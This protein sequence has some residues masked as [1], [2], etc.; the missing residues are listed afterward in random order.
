MPH[1]P[2][3]CARREF[4]HA[5]WTF[6][7]EHGCVTWRRRFLDF[8][9]V[10]AICI[11]EEA[12]RRPVPPGGGIVTLPS[13]SGRGT[14]GSQGEGPQRGRPTCAN[15]PGASALPPLTMPLRGALLPRGERHV[16]AP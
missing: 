4:R 2:H 13:P 15:T 8:L 3:P 11:E 5:S 1:R 6:T 12:T 16:P 10:W 9:P 7:K 14:A